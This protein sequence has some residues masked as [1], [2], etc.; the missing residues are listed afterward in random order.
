MGLGEHS[1]SSLHPHACCSFPTPFYLPP[2]TTLAPPF[3]YPHFSLCRLRKQNLSQATTYSPPP[4]PLSGILSLT[5]TLETFPK[6]PSTFRTLG[7]SG[8]TLLKHRKAGGSRRRGLLPPP[9]VVL[10]IASLRRR[11]NMPVS[12]LYLCAT[13][14]GVPCGY[15]HCMALSG[16]GRQAG[17]DSQPPAYLW[18]RLR[19]GTHTHT[20]LC[21][22]ALNMME[23]PRGLTLLFLLH[24]WGL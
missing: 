5:L 10:N 9:H 18:G 22:H 23:A 13:H 7:E 20:C 16:V 4:S 21:L 12:L 19:G 11:R 14:H 17:G 2:P 8:D 3:A 24:I 15:T 6:F 1:P